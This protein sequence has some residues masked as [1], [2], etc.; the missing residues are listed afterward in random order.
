MNLSSVVNGIFLLKTYFIGIYQL[1]L[2]AILFLID[3][4]FNEYNFSY[5][6]NSY[7]LGYHSRV[8]IFYPLFQS[9]SFTTLISSTKLTKFYFKLFSNFH[10]IF[11]FHYFHAQP[12]DAFILC[13]FRNFE[14]KNIRISSTCDSRIVAA[15]IICIIGLIIV[16]N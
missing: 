14:L 8:T 1:F 16:R 15:S 9:L 6:R 11:Q 3:G 7:E 4:H 5:T 2:S 12:R 10:L 13:L